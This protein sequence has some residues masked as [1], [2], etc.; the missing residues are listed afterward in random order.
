MNDAL[1]NHRKSSV[2]LLSVVSNSVLV[3][4]KLVVG[5]LTGS[6][7]II[8]EAIHSGVDL[9]ASVIAFMSVRTSGRPADDE[10]PFGHGKFENLSGAAEA[11]LIFVAAA[12]IVSEAIHKLANPQPLELLGWG[13]LIMLIS[14]VA[15]AVVSSRLMKVGRET[16]SIALRADAWHLRTDVYTSAGVMV[17]LAV[18]WVCGRV[19]PNANLAWVDPVAAM[20]VAILIVKAAWDLT[21]ESIRDLLD[22]RLARE[23]EA[24][25]QDCVL[26]RRPV[27]IG[28]HGLRTRKAGSSHFIEFHMI[29][30]KSMTVAEAHCI[31]E[32]LEA[33]ISEH[34]AG[35]DV[36]IHVEPCDGSCKPRCV[37]GCLLSDQERKKLQ[38]SPRHGQPA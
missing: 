2:A 7:S 18:I 13:V 8:S 5:T 9:L 12:W 28:M 6:V 19:F 23:E 10:H 30:D 33:A 38:D 31:S 26:G 17:G 22:V 1:V 14:S 4:L 15:N 21:M 11:I 27:V 24:W 36:V 35:S 3:G 32:D 34:F 16:D 25:I 37:K 29:L 20:L